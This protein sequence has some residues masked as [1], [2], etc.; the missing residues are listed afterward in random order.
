MGGLGSGSL[1]KLQTRH[2]LK[3]QSS[4]GL[5][6]AGR[7]D[8]DAHPASLLL[9]LLEEISNVSHMGSSISVLEV[10]PTVLA[11]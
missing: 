5:T 10:Y 11:S 8:P 1:L 7:V 2:W 9:W 6:G 3:L 4:E